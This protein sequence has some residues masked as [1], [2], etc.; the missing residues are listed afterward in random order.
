MLL[1]QVRARQP[2]NDGR[3]PRCGDRS[4]CAYFPCWCHEPAPH[5]RR[6]REYFL[7]SKQ[8]QQN[9]AELDGYL[10]EFVEMTDKKE[11]YIES[12]HAEFAKT[13]HKGR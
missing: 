1:S 12:A 4:Q 5:G 9:R 3:L 10:D 11:A 8:G 6:I 2:S 7:N 13:S